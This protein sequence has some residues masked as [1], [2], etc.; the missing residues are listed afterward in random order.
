MAGSCGAFCS[1]CGKC[2]RKVSTVL[3]TVEVPQV[4]P[5]GEPMSSIQDEVQGDKNDRH[6]QKFDDDI[7][8]A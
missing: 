5:P 6:V 8:E 2:G 7:K 1:F 4:A 3:E